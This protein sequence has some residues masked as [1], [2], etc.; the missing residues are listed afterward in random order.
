MFKLLWA[1]CI[2]HGEILCWELEKK[3]VA[4]SSITLK[5]Q[6]IYYYCYCHYRRRWRWA[7]RNLYVCGHRRWWWNWQKTN[8]GHASAWILPS[9][10]ENSQDRE[11]NSYK[12]TT[13]TNNLAVP[14]LVNSFRTTN[15]LRK[16]IEKTDRKTRK[17]LT[18]ERI[19]HQKEDCNS[20]YIKR[21]NSGHGLVELKSTYNVAITGL[22]AYIKQGKNMLIRL[23][24]EYDS[25][26][27]TK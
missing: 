27:A 24:Q 16:E 20:L 19:H 23:V 7:L 15:W 26:T 21:Q 1:S 14:V 13:A 3:R 10:L 11:L 5:V 2:L 9:C 4:S 25:T 12:K 22:S 8:D 18:N 6:I 17:L